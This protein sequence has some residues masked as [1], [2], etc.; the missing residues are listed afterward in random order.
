MNSTV[1]GSGGATNQKFSV[2][3]IPNRIFP[4]IFIA[5]QLES[6][7]K[8]GKLTFGTTHILLT[9]EILPGRMMAVPGHECLLFPYTL[10]RGRYNLRDFVFCFFEKSGTYIFSTSSSWVVPHRGSN[11]KL[12]H[13]TDSGNFTL[14]MI[15][16]KIFSIFSKIFFK[17]FQNIFKSSTKY[18]QIFC[19]ILANFL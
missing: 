16:N 14:Q 19:K 11:S 2:A 15:E 10:G 17:I 4:P 5:S 7:G 8:N 12:I 1:K 3:T 18:P 9:I 6:E 13:N